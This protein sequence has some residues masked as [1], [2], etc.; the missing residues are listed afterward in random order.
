MA[1]CGSGRL[2][3][4]GI[5]HIVHSVSHAQRN[6]ERFSGAD[7]KAHVG[8]CGGVDVTERGFDTAAEST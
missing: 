8:T 5:R 2:G 6:L 1:N 7:M 3:L 4:A